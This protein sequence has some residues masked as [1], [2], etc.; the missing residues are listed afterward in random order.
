M[1]RL[2]MHSPWSYR[3]A[4]YVLAVLFLV[5]GVLKLSDPDSFAGT[6][7]AFALLPG[8]LADVAALVLPV[9]EVAAAVGLIFDVR[10]SLGVI[11]AL[12][13]VFMAV[14]VYAIAM[15]M[16]IDCGCYG[17]EDPEAEAFSS[18]RTSLE[19]DAGIMLMVVY[20][21]AWRLRNGRTPRPVPIRPA[22]WFGKR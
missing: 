13:G 5:A 2:L 17:P 14:L 4:R 11:G 3:L 8:G 21:Y 20:C 19:R 16:D 15:G 1:V 6:I 9:L 18:L 7:R 12:T 22:A 10:Y